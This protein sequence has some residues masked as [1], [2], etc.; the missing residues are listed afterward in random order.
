MSEIGLALMTNCGIIAL[1]AKTVPV[2]NWV[3]V[4]FLSNHLGNLFRIVKSKFLSKFIIYEPNYGDD[5][6]LHKIDMYMKH[7]DRNPEV[8]TFAQ[9]NERLAS[10]LKS[11]SNGTSESNHDNKNNKRNEINI[12]ELR[13]LYDEKRKYQN[14]EELNYLKQIN[15]HLKIK[16]QHHNIRHEWEEVVRSI[17]KIFFV[18]FVCLILGSVIFIFSVAPKINF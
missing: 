15:E 17:D 7:G 12:S 2:P 10:Q 13:N 4:I 9:L 3:R 18:I 16:S 6:S 8:S 5:T 11:T 14:S 1:D